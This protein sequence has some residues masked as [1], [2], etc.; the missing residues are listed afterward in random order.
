MTHKYA[1]TKLP[2]FSITGLTILSHSL[3]LYRPF[4]ALSNVKISLCFV[5]PFCS[6]YE[7]ANQSGEKY[8]QSGHFFTSLLLPVSTSLL[9]STF[10]NPAS[11]YSADVARSAN[12]MCTSRSRRWHQGPFGPACTSPFI[13]TPS[14]PIPPG[15]NPRRICSLEPHCFPHWSMR[16]FKL[17]ALPT[18]RF[19]SF[20]SSGSAIVEELS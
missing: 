11:R 14:L 19:T 15:Q 9:A 18:F 20:V 6:R 16:R 4:V 13:G 17:V 3:P 7:H 5:E 2:H 8:I 10:G 12:S 1:S